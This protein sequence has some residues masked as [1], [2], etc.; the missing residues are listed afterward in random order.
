MSTSKTLLIIATAMLAAGLIP[1]PQVV[2]PAWTVT[3]LDAKHKPIQG[4]VVRESWQQYSFETSSHE[5]DRLTNA[6]GNVS[7]P[8]RTRWSSFIGRFGGCINQLGLTGVHTSCGAHSYLVAFDNG[9]DTLDWQNS[10]QEDGTTLPW[11]H[12]TLILNH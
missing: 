4:V 10:D 6:E 2:A 3:T 7:F 12:S 1:M 8:R 11:Q 9:I 5:E